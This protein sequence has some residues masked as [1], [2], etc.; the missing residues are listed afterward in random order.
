MPAARGSCSSSSVLA[1]AIRLGTA[2]A[3]IL[4]LEPDE[5]LTI[6]SLV[7]AELYGRAMPVVLLEGFVYHALRDGETLELRAELHGAPRI[8]A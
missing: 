8:L 7:A 5:I 6:G 4:L 2:P 1:E 3:A